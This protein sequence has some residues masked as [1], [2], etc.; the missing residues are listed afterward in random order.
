MQRDYL[1]LAG[2]RH[3]HAGAPGDEPM[4]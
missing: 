2:V 4:R 1:G 3:A